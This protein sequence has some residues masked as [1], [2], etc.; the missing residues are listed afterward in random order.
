MVVG[1]SNIL[2]VSYGSQ[3]FFR[4]KI[5]RFKSTVNKVAH[6]W[7][8]CTVNKGPNI[9]RVLLYLQQISI[10]IVAKHVWL[11]FGW[12]LYERPIYAVS[13]SAANIRVRRTLTVCG[14]IFHT[15]SQIGFR[16]M[17]N[18]L[19]LRTLISHLWWRYRSFE[20]ADFCFTEN[21]CKLK[22]R[23]IVALWCPTSTKISW[24]CPFKSHQCTIE[25]NLVSMHLTW[26]NIDVMTDVITYLSI[27]FID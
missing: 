19:N 4:L 21:V 27:L 24:H 6:P 5:G 22:L 2:G 13:F 17:A 26:N 10:R 15:C 23:P 8:Y 7:M 14:A 12:P 20:T 3:P 18:P 1:M 16:V 9:W 11:M 25:I